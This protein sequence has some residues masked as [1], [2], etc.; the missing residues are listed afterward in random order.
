MSRWLY[1]FKIKELRN[2]VFYVLGLL[3]VFRIFAAIPIPGID[4]AQVQ[5]FFET[6]EFFGLIDVFSGGGLSNFSIMMLGVGPYITASIIMQL[7]TMIVPKLHQLY[8]EDGEQ[9]RRI[10][11]QYTRYL[12]VPL[13]VLQGISMIFLLRQQGV[14]VDISMVEIVTAVIM[15]V[16]G[17]SILMWIGELITTKNVG[18]G[19]S[20]LIFAGIVVSLPSQIGQFVL[21]Y[22]A[23]DLPV[24]LMYLTLVIGVIAL[25]VFVSESQRNIPVS[26]SKG[27]RGV[28]GKMH[29]YLPLKVNQAGVIPIIFALSL[30]TF[31][32][33]IATFLREVDVQW[34]SEFGNSMDLLFQNQT[35]Y[36]SIYF[37]MVIAFTYFYTAIIFEPKIIAENLQK[38]G[39]FIPGIRPGLRTEMYLQDVVN[40]T[41]A[42]GAI[43]LG[44][45]AVLPFIVTNITG[46]SSLA[47]GGTSLL[48]VVSVVI[49]TMKQIDSQIIVRDYDSL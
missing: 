14:I 43:F 22:D 42:V 36:T 29:V 3:F 30:M 20:L 48:I 38:Q 6:N 33:L 24:Y 37:V 2:R 19:I 47:V 18:N 10:F 11:N 41:L 40:K 21:N 32:R 16:A 26:Y 8:K 17:T 31:P 46:N 15:V 12:T 4:V 44:L 5:R 34:I 25:V 28:A 35:F 7:F 39:G 27:A 13:A 23:S 9:G 49:E 45:I 1:V